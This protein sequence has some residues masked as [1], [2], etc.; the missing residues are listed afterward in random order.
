MCRTINEKNFD[1]TCTSHRGRLNGLKYQAR[2]QNMPVAIVLG[3]PIVD[4][5]AAL[6]GV[7]PGT[8]DYEGLG[9]FYGHPAQLGKCEKNDQVA[10][11]NAENVLEG[12]GVTTEGRGQD[13]G[14][15]G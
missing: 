2:G 1:M 3:G 9:S 7:P 13:G 12:E 14:P 10:P 8:A 5:L 6:A 11:A 15:D 4:K